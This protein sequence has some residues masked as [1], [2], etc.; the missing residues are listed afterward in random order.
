M[1][2]FDVPSL[3][4][5]TAKLQEHPRPGPPPGSDRG[6][7]GIWRPPETIPDSM[8]SRLKPRGPHQGPSPGGTKRGHP[9]SFGHCPHWAHG[10][11]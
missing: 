10:P 8:E 7:R 2:L 4:Q 3:K 1:F 11:V 6:P 9:E 5:G